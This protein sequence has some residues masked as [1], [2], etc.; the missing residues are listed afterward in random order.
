MQLEALVKNVRNL[1]AITDTQLVFKSIQELQKQMEKRGQQGVDA[2]AKLLGAEWHWEQEANGFDVLKYQVR[3]TE[4]PD[5]TI[6][7]RTRDNP[8]HNFIF[9]KVR[10]NRVL[11]EGWITGREDLWREDS[12][13][14]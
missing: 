3:S 9:C 4:N 11:I 1:K 12:E 8:D 7:V 14:A 5:T 2:V 13:T 10:E 6:K